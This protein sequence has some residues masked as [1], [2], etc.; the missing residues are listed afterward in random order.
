LRLTPRLSYQQHKPI[1]AFLSSLA[2]HYA[3]AAVGIVLSGSGSDGALGIKAIKERGGL[4]IAQGSDGKRPLHSEMPDAAIASGTVDIVA[5]VE[6]IPARLANYAHSFRL[7]ADTAAEDAEYRSDAGL[8]ERYQPIY[9]LLLR[10][11]GHDF[12]GYKEKTFTRRVR[13][14]MQ[15]IG[16]NQL[17]DYISRLQKDADEVDLLFRDLLI[18]VTN[19]F[20]DPEAFETL[21][22]LVVPRLFEGKPAVDTVRVWCPGCATGEEVYSLA[23]LLREHMDT[24]R[25]PPKVQIFATDIDQHALGIARSGRYTRQLLENVSS[26]RLKRFFISDDVSYTVN[27]E[28]RDMSIFSPQSI[29]RDPPFSRIDLISCRNLL[30]YLGSEF[31]SHVIPLFHFGLRE[32]GFLFLGTSENVTQHGDLFTPIDKKHRIFQRRDHPAAPVRFPFFL[33]HMSGFATVREQRHEPSTA[34]ANLRRTVES[35]V[36]ERFAPAHVVVNSEGDI[37]H[38]SP[39]TG[40]YLEPATGL[41]N[42]QLLAMARRGLRLDLLEALR[43]AVE[44]R[45]IVTREHL[46]VEM[47]DRKQFVDITIEPFGAHDDP[48]FLVL[49][50]DIGRPVAPARSEQASRDDTVTDYS[51]QLEHELHDTRE[52]LQST[53]EEYETAVEELKS[54][55]E[56]LQSINEELQSTNEELE[57]SKEELQSVNEE[58]NTVNAELNSKVDEVDRAHSDLRNLFDSTQIATIFLDKNLCIRFFTPAATSLFNL[59]SSDRG[60][61]L[62]DIASSLADCDLRRDVETVFERGEPIERNVRRSGGKA[63]YLMRVL[64]YHGQNRVIDGVIVTFVEITKLVQAEAQQRTLVEELN[65]RVRNMLTVVNAIA[66]QTLSQTCSPQEFAKAFDGRIQAMAASYS[67]VSRENWNEVSLREL[68]MEQVK[69]HQVGPGERIEISGPELQVKPTAALVL[70]LVGHELTTNATK[71]GSLSRPSGRVSIS[72]AIEY[73]S[74]PLLVLQWTETGGPPA[75]K[76][77]RNGFG[78]TLIER[79]LRQ[80]L[81]GSA[82]FRY[83]E[84]GFGATL[85]IPLDPNLL[86]FGSAS[87][88]S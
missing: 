50:N 75:R 37:L 16:I 55:N 28:L 86:S 74:I 27:K 71:Y 39:R 2:E 32:R 1:D 54:S 8:V 17:D 76:P 85:S 18:G 33:P 79:E 20:R 63:E 56:E 69:P 49:F 84:T 31:Q 14:R 4:T 41:P 21:A 57:T 62:T 23:I 5:P 64:P 30:I 48:L 3:E 77:I 46:E 19:F 13:H 58:L 78:T 36:V 53:I 87:K 35:R 68:I 65:H 72:W 66:K 7:L 25:T 51:K 9:H 83:N 42:R 6:Q 26:Q 82:Q 40:K 81:G 44:L 43:Q 22:Q 67:L 11:A 73:G 12:S 10:R 47:D 24:F 88:P 80:T 60:R 15:V 45:T 52:R 38:F 34:A 70:G 59:I 61:P 29:I